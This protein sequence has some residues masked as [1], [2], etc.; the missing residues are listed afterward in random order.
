M[1]GF[2][3]TDVNI[4]L[5]DDDVLLLKILDNKFKK[6]TQYNVLPFRSGEDFLHYYISNQV[7]K[8]QIQIV[9]LDYN[10]STS[11][12]N[13]KDGLEIL[14]YIKEISQDVHVII[15]S[16]FVSQAVSDKMKKLG[17]EVCIKK[18]ENSYIRIQNTIKW[19][20]SERVIKEKKKQSRLTLAIFLTVL[21][22]IVII[23]VLNFLKILS[24]SS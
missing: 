24:F 1:F 20:I 19:I 5:V 12:N 22:I 23:G 18:N 6:T 4:Y 17:A 9:I 7:K 15:L 21:F 16:G 14:K 13:S 2:K 8:N 11:D 10:L 3:E